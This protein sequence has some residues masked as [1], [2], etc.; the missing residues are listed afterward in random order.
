VLLAGNMVGP[1]ID[2]SKQV[3]P[4]TAALPAAAAVPKPGAV[5]KPG[6]GVASLLDNFRFFG[7]RGTSKFVLEAG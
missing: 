5:F 1:S 4:A 7:S 3:L 6:M 2:W